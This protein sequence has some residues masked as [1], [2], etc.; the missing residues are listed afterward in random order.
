M[1]AG[2]DVC[3][4]GMINKFLFLRCEFEVQVVFTLP[5]DM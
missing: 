5:F 4:S 3:F 2:G 1:P